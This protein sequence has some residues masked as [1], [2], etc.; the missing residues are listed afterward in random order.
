MPTYDEDLLNLDEWLRRLKIEYHIFFS[1]NRRN[2]P[3][4]LRLR[5]ERTVKKLSECTDMSYSQ[6]FRYTTLITRYYVYRD[7]WR[8]MQQEREL[9]AE[10]KGEPVPSKSDTTPSPS[11]RSKDAVRISIADPKAEEEKVRT[12][13]DAL[14][15]IRSVN[16]KETPPSYQQ[17][18]NYIA[19]QTRSIREKY[20]CSQ[21]AFT[22]AL[23]DDAIRFTAAAEKC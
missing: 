18:A 6:R 12:L 8:R 11:D 9:G 22:I 23:E 21:V 13:Y 2:P 20:G 7:K 15:R 4:D 3:D 19:T 5:V 16:A 14:V 10:P 1:G 17:F